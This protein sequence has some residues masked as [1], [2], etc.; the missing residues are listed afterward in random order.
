MQPLPTLIFLGSNLFFFASADHAKRNK[1]TYQSSAT[2]GNINNE[3]S[4]D[5]TFIHS[6]LPS[7]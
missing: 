4:D 5:E 1:N 7:S 6:K 3:Q 2:Q